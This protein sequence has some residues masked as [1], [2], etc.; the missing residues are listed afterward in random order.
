MMRFLIV[1]GIDGSD[2][3]HWQ[4]LWEADWGDAAVRIAPAS[5]SVPDLDD[6]IEAIDTG[7]SRLGGSDLLVVAHS[8]GC[9]AAA[10]WA[11]TRPTGAGGLFLVAPPDVTGPQFPS[12][13]KNFTRAGAGR[14]PVPALVVSSDDDPYCSPETSASLAERWGAGHVTAGSAGHLNSAS[15]VADWRFGRALLVAF[16]AGLTTSRRP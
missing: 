13:A 10:H 8:L 14:L 3:G 11:S 2:A 6:W 16:T 1:P 9:L 5:W 15:A 12:V 4:S 7:A